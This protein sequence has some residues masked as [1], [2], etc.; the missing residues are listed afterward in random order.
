MS[1]GVEI[2]SISTEYARVRFTADV[3]LGSQTVEL[4]FMA[5]MTAE[6]GPTDWKA[7]TWLGSAGTT[8]YAGVLV[9]PDGLV[10]AEAVW[11]VWARLTDTPEKPAWRAG[12]IS[13]T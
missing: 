1:V 9:G 3:E 4:A 7:A 2:P 11:W 5:S 10:L 13:I 12:R 6:P 8:R